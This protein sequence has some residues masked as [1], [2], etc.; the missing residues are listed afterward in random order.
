MIWLQFIVG[1]AIQLEAIAPRVQWRNG[2]REEA[3]VSGG[4]PR[5]DHG[6]GRYR[7][8]GGHRPGIGA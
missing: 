2:S 8:V 6:P 1:K 7:A 4:H 3:V 5:L